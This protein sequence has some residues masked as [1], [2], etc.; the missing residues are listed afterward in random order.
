[1]LQLRPGSDRSNAEVG[2][3]LGS[4]VQLQDD[5]EDMPKRFTVTA[6]YSYGDTTVEK[7][8]EIDLRQFA[9]KVL[10]YKGVRRELKEI[11]EA[12]E[13]ISDSLEE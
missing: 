6:R 5:P 11:R 1:M 9:K 8:F 2:Y 10:V 7:D 12:A 3:I 13:D 4:T